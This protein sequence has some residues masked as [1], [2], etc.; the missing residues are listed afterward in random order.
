M[1]N[2]TDDQGT[3]QA[4]ADPVPY[5]LTLEGLR[6]LRK[7]P[8]TPAALVGERAEA[9]VML[10]EFRS[11]PATHRPAQP[12]GPGAACGRSGALREL[13]RWFH[14]HHTP[15][16][17]TPVELLAR[18]AGGTGPY[19]MVPATAC[20]RQ[21]HRGGRVM[22][23]LEEHLKRLIREVVVDA[24]RHVMAEERTYAPTVTE[25]G[26]A[27]R[28]A[29]VATLLG[30]HRNTVYALVDAGDLPAERPTGGRAP[31]ISTST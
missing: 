17:V 16:T 14:G 30:V 20:V 4:E 24:V 7:V 19:L 22:D 21:R 26:E 9:R 11:H 1:M 23:G 13:I 10:D 29:E 3:C 2:A 28:P 5:T 25:L 27:L 18:A 15:R 12:A 8:A 6:A 31:V